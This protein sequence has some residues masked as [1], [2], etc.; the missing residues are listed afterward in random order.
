MSQMHS[1]APIT[2]FL[3]HHYRHF[4]A[5]ALVDAMEDPEKDRMASLQAISHTQFIVTISNLVGAIP[6]SILIDRIYKAVTGHPF[7]TAAEAEHG[8]HM[9]FPHTSGT[10][11][12]AI[13]TGVFLWLSSLATELH[14]RDRP[15]NRAPGTPCRS[16][17]RG[18]PSRALRGT[19]VEAKISTVA[20]VD[21]PR[22]WHHH[23]DRRTGH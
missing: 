11:F 19:L 13:V 16:C 17:D 9:L 2:S 3:K 5:A 10:I 15:G 8:V 1:P 14:L 23:R 7:L 22:A 4:N 21:M 18:P 12:F 20:G 6:V